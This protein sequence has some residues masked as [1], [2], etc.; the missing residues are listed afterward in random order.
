MKKTVLKI[1]VVM[2]FVFS[3]S[4]FLFITEKE[5]AR[6]P[7]HRLIMGMNL[8]TLAYW[9]REL[10]FMDLFKTA[11]PWVTQN[12]PGGSGKQGVWDTG[13]I[14]DIPLDDDGYP[15]Y[16]PVTID[17]VSQVVATLL[18]R[19]TEGHYPRGQY[20]C[21]YDGQGEI[22]FGYDA[23]TVHQ[24]PGRIVLA[25]TP[26]DSGIL[27][28]IVRSSRL[29]PIRNIRVLMPGF[30]ADADQKVFNPRFLDRLKPFKVIRFM[31]WQRT[32]NA[33]V[34]RWEDRTRLTFY[35]QATDRGVAAETM[36]DLCNRLGAMPWFCIPHG[37]DNDYILRFAMLVKEQL[38][39]NLSI[40]L[41]YSNEVWNAAFKQYHWVE[42][43]GPEGLNLPQKY[44][45]FA[46]NAFNIWH[47]VFGDQ[48]N[49]VIRV[50][51][52]QQVR[53]WIVEQAMNL[54]GGKGVDAVSS[55]GYFGLGKEDYDSLKV[56][57]KSATKEEVMRR[58]TAYMAKQMDGI[59]AHAEIAADFHIDFVVY[60]GGQSISPIPLGTTPPFTDAMW[61][62]QQSIE[63]YNAYSTFFSELKNTDVALFNLYAFVSRQRSPF[64]SWGHLDY[65]DQPLAD[66]PKYRAVLDFLDVPYPD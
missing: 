51:C 20:V 24:Q 21:R 54:L 18:C 42:A 49:R 35:T 63:M 56:L 23:S 29:N 28:K 6:R 38:N 17:G 66:A 47:Q 59:R 26:S 33:T 8:F 45:R 43:N 39:P 9:S 65:I 14:H 19:G 60:E 32:N 62:A 4:C 50:I 25:V 31:D 22:Q 55:S 34:T 64:G 37:A 7:E 61:E 52:G 15:K 46:K 10:P 12:M 41:E 1:V 30:E 16:L 2:V 3:L 5:T 48:K 11:G 57:G 40:Y 36:I 27:V 13:R 58:V 53:P 44:A